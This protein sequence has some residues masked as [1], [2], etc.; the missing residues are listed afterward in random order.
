MLKNIT[1]SADEYLLRRAREKA[2]S[3]HTTLNARFRQWL[4]RYAAS[5]MDR[6]YMNLMEELSYAKPLRRYSRDELNER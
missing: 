1:L 6:E 4:E 5:N 3:E 2:Q